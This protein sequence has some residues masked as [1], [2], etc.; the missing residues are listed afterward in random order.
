VSARNANAL[1]CVAGACFGGALEFPLGFLLGLLG[2]TAWAHSLRSE[3]RGDAL[4]GLWIG[5]VCAV[6]WYRELPQIWNTYSTGGGLLFY[7]ALVVV[8]AL[9]FAACGLALGLVRATHR[10]FAL[11]MALAAQCIL[12][13]WLPVPLDLAII[14][15]TWTPSLWPVALV[16]TPGFC[17]CLGIV[18]AL[19]RTRPVAALAATG[20]WAAIGLGWHA[21]PMPG[22]TVAVSLVQPDI[23]PF[24]ARRASTVD[25]REERI[26]TLIV[27]AA[28]LPLLPETAWPGDPSELDGSVVGHVGPGPSNRLTYGSGHFDKRTLL[29]IAETPFLGVGDTHFQRGQR[30]RKLATDKVVFTPLICFEDLVPSAL[31][32]AA[33]DGG[34]PLLLATNDSWLG[35]AGDKHLRGSVLA[36][37]RTGRWAARP[38]TSGPSAII[39]PRGRIRARTPAVDWPEGGGQLLEGHVGGQSPTLCGAVLAPILSWACLLGL[40]GLVRRV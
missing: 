5:V 21:L 3:V 12:L 4:R 32:E 16:G 28:G 37:V 30:P 35:R 13:A 1:A 9:P 25:D 34:G 18:G 38:A 14:G 39:D 29:P 31:R 15:T 17:L 11:P 40:L 2:V 36:A 22:P 20:L 24:D 7:G 19:A 23:D 33:V 10:E 27:G 6:V 26:R 8:Q